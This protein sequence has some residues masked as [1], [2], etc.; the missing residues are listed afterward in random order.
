MALSLVLIGIM[1]IGIAGLLII[2]ARETSDNLPDSR[3]DSE[4][5]PP[6]APA[7]HDLRHVA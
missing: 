4:A 3:P 5:I 6:N 1:V 7:D 2:A